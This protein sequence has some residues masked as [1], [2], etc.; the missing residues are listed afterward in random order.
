MAESKIEWTDAT[1][2]PIGGCSIKSPGCAPCYAQRLAGTRLKNHP[3]YKGTTTVVKGKPVFNGKLTIAAE[4]HS[5]WTW[6][7][8]WRGA[9][10]PRLGPGMPSL[11]FVGDMSDLF[12]EDRPDADIDR[13]IKVMGACD[14]KGRTHI[15]QLLTK[16]PDRMFA[17]LTT[18][19]HVAWNMRRLATEAWPARNAWLGMSAERQKEFDERWPHLRAL[20]QFGWTTFVSY[21]P[22]LGPLVLP[23]DFLALGARAQVIAGGMSG[24]DHPAHQRWFRSLRDQCEPAGVAFFFKQWGEWLPGTQYEQ[25]HRDRDPELEQ[26]RFRCMDWDGDRPFDTDGHWTDETS[27][28]ACWRVGKKY[29]GRRLDGVTHDGFPEVRHAQ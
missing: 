2:N 17:Y 26:S 20:A 3:L 14:D 29:A 11:I 13:V 7:L 5:T 28:D 19:G 10:A 22:A 25:E 12:H 15:F 23:D 21:E 18:R 4:G 9:S 8:S 16:R 24:E 27:E 6:P 1:W